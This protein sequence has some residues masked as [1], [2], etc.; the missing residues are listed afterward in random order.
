REYVAQQKGTLALAIPCL[1]GGAAC[2]ALIAYILDPMIKYLFIEKRMDMVLI[3]PGIALGIV[4]L[5]AIFNY[6]EAVFMNSLG[7]NVVTG[8]QRDMAR[9]IFGIDLADL[10]KVHSGQFISN[11]LYDATLLR[12]AVT[13][14]IAA[15]AKELVSLVLFTAVLVYQDWQLSLVM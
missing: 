4:I 11:F 1:V 8:S 7:Q 10:N 5:R 2:A 9:S 12:D 15:C 6:G 14:G 13:K 3:V